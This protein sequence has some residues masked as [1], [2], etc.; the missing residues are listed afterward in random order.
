MIRVLSSSDVETHILPRLTLSALLH[1]QA[2]AL[3][4]LPPSSSP[5]ASSA[6]CPARLSLK[7]P[8]YTQLFMPAR[9][10]SAASVVKCVS[11]PLPGAGA[12]AGI[13][14]VNLL[15]SDETGCVTHVVNSTLL[16][17]LRTAAGS[18]LSSVLALAPTR[19]TVRCGVVFGDGA[20]AIFHVWL[21]LRYFTQLKDITL[22]VSS[23]KQLTDTELTL[24]R[25][26]F[27]TKLRSLLATGAGAGDV[28]SIRV[29][30]GTDAAE[31][32]AAVRRSELVFT[33]TPSTKALFGGAALEGRTHVCAVGSYQPHM[34]ELPSSLVHRAATEGTLWVDSTAACAHEAGCLLQAIPPQQLHGAVIEL[35]SLLHDPHTAAGGGNEKWLEALEEKAAEWSRTNAGKGGEEGVVSVFKS[36]GVGLQDV[37]V[38]RLVVETAGEDVG[39]EVAF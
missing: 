16:T 25:D 6:Q 23:H 37:E 36:V 9:T 24:K 4:S 31:V 1:S 21:H 26:H 13:P 38:T 29:V 3:T 35:G 20:Q 18:L 19:S 10:P 22:V 7:T 5:S 2:L 15:F 39:T 8:Q 28:P 30:S 34:C 17:A 33:C 11:V 32:D 27:T 12:S 14:G